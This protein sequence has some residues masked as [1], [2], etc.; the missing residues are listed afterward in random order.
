MPFQSRLAQADPA[1]QTSDMIQ[2]LENNQFFPEGYDAGSLK[3][4]MFKEI[5]GRCFTDAASQLQIGRQHDVQSQPRVTLGNVVQGIANALPGLSLQQ[6]GDFVLGNMEGYTKG[7]V[8]TPHPTEMLSREAITAELDLTDL[9]HTQTRRLLT[10]PTE[11]TN[12][13][14]AQ[15]NALKGAMQTLFDRLSPI[16]RPLTISEEMA[17]SVAFSEKMF[18]AVPIIA[19]NALNAAKLN[20][21]DLTED[22]LRKLFNVLQPETWSPGDRDSKPD[23]TVEELEKGIRLNRRAMM[24]H[25]ARHLLDVLDHSHGT[26]LNPNNPA[27]KDALQMV[28]RLIVTAQQNEDEPEFKNLS[29]KDYIN[30]RL[31]LRD[32]G[33]GPSSA[34]T[35]LFTFIETQNDA[36]REDPKAYT[37]KN[38][39]INDLFALR[40][41]GEFS[42]YPDGNTPTPLTEL[43]ALIVRA[44]NFGMTALHSQIRQNR[45]IHEKVFARVAEL[46]NQS[47]ELPAGTNAAG[48]LEYMRDENARLKVQE[49]IG[50]ELS[51]IEADG[52]CQKRPSDDAHLDDFYFYQ[53]LKGMELAAQNPEFVTHYL[54]AECANSND[55]LEANA[56]LKL[57][58]PPQDQKRGTIEI[59]PL[60]EHPSQVIE[61]NGE[62][63]YVR[64]M[65]EVFSNK[66]FRD[67]QKQASQQQYDHLLNNVSLKDGQVVSRR[68]T[69]QDLLSQINPEYHAEKHPEDATKEIGM[70]KLCMGAGSDITK[71]GGIAAAALIQNAMHKLKEE[72]LTLD[73]PVMLI[74]YIGCGGGVHRTQPVSTSYETVQGRSMRQ[75]PEA[76]SLKISSLIARHM[77]D[78]LASD[79][80]WTVDKLI[81]TLP[82]ELLEAGEGV[83]NTPERAAFAAKFHSPLARHISIEERNLLAQVNLGNMA[84]IPNTPT[85]WEKSSKP[86]AEKASLAYQDFVAS[87]E[88]G[89]YLHYTGD[90]FAKL[91]SYAARPT[92]RVSANA[93]KETFPPTVQMGK[94]RAIGYGGALNSCGSCA[95]MFMGL[96]SI[97]DKLASDSEKLQQV[98]AIEPKFQDMINRATYGVIMADMDTAWRY[99]GE[100][101]TPSSEQLNTLAQETGDA[102]QLNL[103]KRALAKI[104]LEHEAVGKGLLKLHT[105]LLG[106]SAPAVDANAPVQEQLLSVL[107]ETLREQLER[108][109]ENIAMPRQALAELFRKFL[110]NNGAE[111]DNSSA[112]QLPAAVTD[113]I[114]QVQDNLPKR[115]SEDDQRLT[116]YYSNIVYPAMAAVME[117]FEHV[118]RAYV[119]PYWALERHRGNNTAVGA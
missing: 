72:L 95:S 9:L 61:Q 83:E 116:S 13:P 79:P 58:E 28:T 53:T 57:M 15:R 21:T 63:P 12:L 69:K 18:D 59:V 14:A 97:A 73:E 34:V 41:T 103:A 106:K 11:A 50:R 64:M 4:Q 104:T 74:D 16:E 85:L 6:M 24:R 88:Y 96:G 2:T 47:Q 56:L 82:A 19:N 22:N 5:I 105:S 10:R 89:A 81:Q 75:T 46:L 39:L 98:Y 8:Q 115:K 110:T 100:A 70:C 7:I 77:R 78:R 42:V 102:D 93:T 1:P 87:P 30:Q 91:T 44:G 111:V 48:L 71:S 52:H 62:I 37:Q 68:L 35:A 114:A 90:V 119:A 51:R 118:P 107:P 17:R 94:L 80:E 49:V 76:I 113:T 92:N 40:K 32:T 29:L 86:L 25:Y 117:C 31:Q 20:S 55:M 45:D 101:K 27:H 66:D 108:S 33:N 84:N 3:G 60:V 112:P 65:K 23:M 36:Q 99:L 67:H 26:D 43:D 109:R 38:Q 54:I